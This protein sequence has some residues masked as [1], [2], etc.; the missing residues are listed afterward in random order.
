MTD[1]WPPTGGDPWAAPDP[2]AAGGPGWGTPPEP[3]RGPVRWV[4]FAVLAA[5]ALVAAGLTVATRADR[6]DPPR[7]ARPAATAT[8]TARPS[9][10]PASRPAARPS[11]PPAAVPTPVRTYSAPPEAVPVHGRV[12]DANGRPVAGALVSLTQEQGAFEAFFTAFAV[13][14]TLG[15][16]CLTD[17]CELPYGEARSGADG[18]YTVYLE[19]VPDDYTLAVGGKDG[20]LVTATVRFAG[21]PVR[22]PDVAVWSPAPYLERRGNEARVRFRSPPARLGS[23]VSAQALVAD[24]NDRELVRLDQARSGDA[25][26]ARLLEDAAAR[27][28]VTVRVRSALGPTA[29]VART[30]VSGGLRPVS[31]GKPCFEYGRAGRPIRQ[32]PCGLT[33][34]D[35]V[36]NW[37]PKVADYSCGENNPCDRR[38]MVDLGSARRLSFLVARGC[39]TFFDE[40]ESSVDGRTWTT[41]ADRHTDVGDAH[42]VCAL[43]LDTVARY[44]RLKGPAGGFYL[45]RAEISLF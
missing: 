2:W 45:S 40:I 36:R 42:D 21:R 1:S 15:L 30:A 17:I 23:W 12:V 4:P 16:A 3:P 34:G 33:D 7:A 29:Y 27:L 5:V 10:P 13:L 19:K 44:V 20:P 31:R 14:G 8:P 32:S 6:R 11:R 39:D 18:R 22:L 37:S 28:S 43:D 26:D 24:R 25:F 9:T 35:L 38:V 41:L